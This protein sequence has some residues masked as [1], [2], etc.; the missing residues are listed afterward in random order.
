MGLG[1]SD[2]IFIHLLFC[3]FNLESFPHFRRFLWCFCCALLMLFSSLFS[4]SSFETASVVPNKIEKY[5]RP[6]DAPSKN[7][8]SH[9]RSILIRTDTWYY[10][11]KFFTSCH[12]KWLPDK[13]W[14]KP[15][16]SISTSNSPILM[17][18]WSVLHQSQTCYSYYSFICRLMWRWPVKGLLSY[19]SLPGAA[20]LFLSIIFILIQ[21]FSAPIPSNPNLCLLPKV[22]TASGNIAPTWTPL[23]FSS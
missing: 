12:F 6:F 19:S 22:P 4:I 23:P 7:A 17:Y 11:F 13:F 9:Q 14:S 5:P 8:M 21:K 16:Q 3:S 10:Y 15:M 2:G 1:T 20:S 18:S